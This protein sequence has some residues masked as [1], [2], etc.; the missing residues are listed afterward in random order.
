MISKGSARIVELTS[1]ERA[2]QIME[3]LGLQMSHE[4]CKYLEE[5]YKPWAVRVK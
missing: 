5:L 2:D 1:V 3:G 4:R